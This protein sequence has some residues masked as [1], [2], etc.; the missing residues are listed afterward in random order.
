MVCIIK[1]IHVIFNIFSKETNNMADVRQILQDF[2]NGLGVFEKDLPENMKAFAGLNGASFAEGALSV[3]TK[4][5]IAVGISAYNRCQYCIVAHVRG[6]LAAGATRQEILE[7][8]MVA[9]AFGG[10]P[11]MAYSATLILDAI[12]EFEKD[13]K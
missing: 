2:Q 1:N 6:A 7:A 5:L 12:D 11:S 8:A 9:V 10:G 13:F 3:K 4:E